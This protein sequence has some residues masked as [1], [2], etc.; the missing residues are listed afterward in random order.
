MHALTA[1]N[2]SQLHYQVI[3]LKIENVQAN[4]KSAKSL[5]NVS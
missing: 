1:L 3:S 5:Q 2:E 4:K